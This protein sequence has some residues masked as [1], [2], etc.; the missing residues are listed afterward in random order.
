VLRRPS[1]LLALVAAVAAAIALV[2]GVVSGDSSKPLTPSQY[3]VELRD[4]LD[5]FTVLEATGAEGIE[6]LAGKFRAAGDELGEV[7]PP[8]ETAGVHARLVA[9]LRQYGDWLA[10]RAESGRPGAVTL[11]AQLAEHQM[12]GADWIA[13]FKE[14]AEK[15]Y[16]SSPAP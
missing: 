8:A 4:A 11:E 10:E 12:A 5:G 1:F 14:L 9:G 13:A 3:R 15:G 16:L 7:K 2:P 6:E